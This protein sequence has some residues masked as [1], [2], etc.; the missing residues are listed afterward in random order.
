LVTAQDL[1]ERELGE[2]LARD[3]AE[4][5]RWEAS[6]FDQLTGDKRNKLVLCGAGGLGRKILA[7]LRLA[8]IEPRCFADHSATLAG[9]TVDGLRVLT[10]REAANEFRHEAAFVVTIWGAHS[11]DRL[12]ERKAQ[13]S[14]LGCET[15]VSF[16]PLFW[17]F[18]KAYLPHYSCDL[19]HKVFAHSQSVARAGRLWADD[20]SRIEFNAQIR[21]RTQ[22]DFD[23]L[24]AP[25]SG[26]AY[27]PKDVVR[28]KTDERFVDCGAFD[29]DTLRDFLR[30][31]GGRFNSYWAL[32]PD[33]ANFAKLRTLIDTL[34]RSA[35]ERLKIFPIAASHRREMLRFA[36]GATA[37]SNLDPAGDL[38]VQGER[39]DSLLGTLRPSF[40]KMD[41]EGAEPAALEGCA[42]LLA[43]ARPILAVSAYHLQEHV[44]ELPLYLAERLDNYRFFLRPHDLEGWDLVLYAIPAERPMIPVAGHPA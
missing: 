4:V 1:R 6:L 7:G 28:L 14:A 9:Q 8:G 21:W 32:E 27:F 38:E 2:I 25:G 44:W 15:V 17:K 16:M 40:I 42:G 33:P 23:G 36:A 12:A 3:P 19:P 5:R 29:G 31:S 22:L 41:I 39:L 18:P 13:W 30:A 11:R 20:V 37:S 34:D 24:P 43:D 26:P 10:P 35:K